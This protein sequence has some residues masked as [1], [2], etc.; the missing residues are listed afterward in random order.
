M[1][2]LTHTHRGGEIVT[3]MAIVLE[4]LFLIEKRVNK[5]QKSLTKLFMRS[6]GNSLACSEHKTNISREIYI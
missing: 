1:C 2:T 3:Q 5:F 6:I 4:C